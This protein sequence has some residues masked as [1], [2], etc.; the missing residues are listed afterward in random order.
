M[1]E[2]RTLQFRLL[3]DTVDG[4]Y[5]LTGVGLLQRQACIST[6]YGRAEVKVDRYKL[7]GLVAFEH[8]IKESSL[9]KILT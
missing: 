8:R 3:A 1:S 6:Q 4:E 9:L 2:V 7:V 5:H